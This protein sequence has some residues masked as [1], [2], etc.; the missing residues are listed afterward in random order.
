MLIKFEAAEN[1]WRN[2][3]LVNWIYQIRL[4]LLDALINCNEHMKSGWKLL[5]SHILVRSIEAKRQN[6]ERQKNMTNFK[7]LS[8]C[9][10]F[11]SRLSLSLCLSILFLSHI[12]LIVTIFVNNSTQP[13]LKNIHPKYTQN[14]IVFRTE[15]VPKNTSF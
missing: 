15:N 10:F 2:I 4:F 12:F 6:S 7:I 5:I 1:I 13:D 3:N 8:R 11:V 14:T 9:H